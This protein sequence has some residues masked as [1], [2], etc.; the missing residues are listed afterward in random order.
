MLALQFDSW[1]ISGGN[2]RIAAMSNILTRSIYRYIFYRQRKK[3]Q[4]IHRVIVGTDMK[5]NMAF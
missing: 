2:R 1:Q 5:L 3:A 4:T